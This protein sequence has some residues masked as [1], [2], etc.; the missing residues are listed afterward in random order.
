[1]VNFN[2]CYSMY[3]WGWIEREREREMIDICIHTYLNACIHTYTHNFARTIYKEAGAAYSLDLTSH[4]ASK[5]I[6]LSS[7]WSPLSWSV[8][9]LWLSICCTPSW[10]I[11]KSSSVSCF[12]RPASPSTTHPHQSS[13]EHLLYCLD[14]LLPPHLECAC[15]IRLYKEDLLTNRI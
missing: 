8:L 12:R 14:N 4:Y 1:M 11:L 2:L 7:L 13:W 10:N 6:T 3:I 5:P 15:G 9:A